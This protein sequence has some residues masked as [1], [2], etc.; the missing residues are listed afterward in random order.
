V[1]TYEDT[2]LYGVAR[3]AARKVGANG[4]GSAGV[5]G[6]AQRRR[7]SRV[8]QSGVRA[9]T[10]IQLREIFK[11]WH[12]V[13]WVGAHGVLRSVGHEVGDGLSVRNTPA[14]RSP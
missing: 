12:A 1:R 3:R 6:R 7:K 2:R 8:A 5:R 14:H 13:R 4:I 11:L 9:C 10:S